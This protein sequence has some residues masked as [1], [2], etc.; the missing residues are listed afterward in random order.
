VTGTH[1]IAVQLGGLRRRELG[2]FLL[3]SAIAHLG[4]LAVFAYSPAS[5]ISAPRG[6]V[7]VDLVAAP[8][9]VKA[10]PAKAKPASPPAPVKSKKVVLPAK[11]KTPEPKPKVI[12]KPKPKP[13]V[14]PPPPVPAQVPEQQYEDVLA[15]LREES[16]ESA[17]PDAIPTA[18]PAV[19]GPVGSPDGVVI[20]PEV[21]AWMKRAK[22]HMRKNWVVPPGFRTQFLETLVEVDLGSSGQLRG[23]PRVKRSSGNPWYDD[24]VLRAIQ[25]SSPLPA[26][27]EAG[28][29]TIM[30]TPEDSY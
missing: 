14:V 25:K 8:A 4:L 7:M 6:V 18:V 22:I 11:P 28:K 15:Q 17:P 30:F 1:E 2:P 20:S 5:H 29:W 13:K 26:P 12:A 24:G 21:M 27:P 16:G 3:A 9:A 23:A 10:A 19:T